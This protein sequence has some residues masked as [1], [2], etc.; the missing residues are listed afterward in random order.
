MRSNVSWEGPLL[1]R[2]VTNGR[3]VCITTID[4]KLKNVFGRA[5]WLRKKWGKENEEIISHFH[6]FHSNVLIS[7]R[8]LVKNL[9]IH[10]YLNISFKP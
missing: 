1:E 4:C 5:S 2:N 6:N 8:E 7:R 3:S 10:F 9:L